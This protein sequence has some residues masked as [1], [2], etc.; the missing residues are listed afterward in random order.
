MS[1]EI[2]DLKTVYYFSNKFSSHFA[3]VDYIRMSALCGT[4]NETTV[5]TGFRGVALCG[6]INETIVYTGFR[7][8]S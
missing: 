8:V 7:G 3:A 2:N 1:S 5:Y 4:I 6:T